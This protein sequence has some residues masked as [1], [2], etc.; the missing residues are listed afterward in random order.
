MIFPPCHC[1][2]T[3]ILTQ[4]TFN[5]VLTKMMNDGYNW[6]SLFD[7]NVRVGDYNFIGVNDY[8]DIQLF[9]QSCYYLPVNVCWD[10]FDNIL[11]E[12]AVESYLNS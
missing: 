6:P 3:E 4:E 10:T 12:L 8:G 7:K 11:N 2:P 1:I 9:S 5:K